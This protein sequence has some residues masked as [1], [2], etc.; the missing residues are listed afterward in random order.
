MKCIIV[1]I[2]TITFAFCTSSTTIS[3]SALHK[4]MD[5]EEL[6]YYFGT[7]LENELP[8]YEIVDLPEGL[9]FGRES[10]TT[11]GGEDDLKYV[12]FKV[13]NKQIELNLYPN[14]VLVSPYTKIAYKNGNLSVNEYF[15]SSAP[16]YCHYLHK[17]SHSTA[18]IS[19]CEPS[20]IHGLIFLPDDS[21]EILPL[22]GRLKGLMPEYK[23]LDDTRTVTI[24]KIPHLVKRSVF[25]LGTFDNDFVNP[26][27]R[28]LPVNYKNYRNDRG[29]SYERPTI[30]LGLFFDEAF[31]NIFSPFFENDNKKLEDFI[32]S[33]VNGMQSLYHHHTLGRNIDFTIVYLEIMKKQPIN[34]PH[35]YGERNELIDNFCEYQKKINPKDDR[36]PQHWD[37]SVYV[38]GLDFFAWDP[39]GFKNG[40]TMGLATVGGVCQ[41]DFN[42]II[43]E[44]G[45]N[46]QFGKPYPSA[47]YTSVYI[48]AH[49]IGHNLGMV[50]IVFLKYFLITFIF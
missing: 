28:H 20:E 4:F 36:N 5:L 18:A 29:L 19:N 42:C 43:A 40:A 46:N 44:F 24:T 22:T 39:N 31:F 27:F 35:A 11:N 13:F 34:M 37:M 33:Y 38:S 32:L 23:F 10:V 41:E 47:G 25:T 6:Q 7:D 16:K 48:L 2:V 45:T 14:K 15:A 50:K 21:L 8:D 49:E 12:N 17:N 9:D 26:T 1:I 30:E 3:R